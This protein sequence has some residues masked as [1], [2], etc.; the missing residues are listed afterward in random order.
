MVLQLKNEIKISDFLIPVQKVE[1]EKNLK[2]FTDSAILTVPKSLKFKNQDAFTEIDSTIFKES[3]KVSINLYYTESSRS[4]KKGNQFEGYVSNFEISN[5]TVQIYCEDAM[6]FLKKTIFDFSKKEISL[7]ELGNYIISKVN[8]THNLNLDVDTESLDVKIYNI[9]FIGATGLDILQMLQKKYFLDSYFINSKLHIGINFRSQN[10]QKDLDTDKR[11]QHFFTSY[12]AEIVNANTSLNY[13]YFVDFSNLKFQ[14]ENDVNLCINVKVYSKDGK[15]KNYKFGDRE[16]ESRDVIMY[17]SPSQKEIEDFY[18]NQLL[19]NKYSG[20]QKGS[21]F[22]CLGNVE[23]NVLDVVTFDG[24]G[25]WRL[26]SVPSYQISEI[27][28]YET[29]SYLVESV[30]ISYGA[31]GFEQQIYISNSVSVNGIGQSLVSKIES[32]TLKLD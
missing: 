9:D 27:K 29:G 4:L 5:D 7:K 17:G 23:I 1:I 13:N 14:K 28:M 12:P 8:K 26:N 22:K 31:S 2:T 6:Y 11:K 24:V 3:D 32:N 30:K 25:Y 18:K 15:Q 21:F 19:R 10:I 20:F 16:G